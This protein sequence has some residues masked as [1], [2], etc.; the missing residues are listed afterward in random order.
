MPYE[1]LF[2][3]GDYKH[4]QVFANGLRLDLYIEYHF[5]YYSGATNYTL[6]KINK[7]NKQL[8]K[9]FARLHAKNVS[10]HFDIPLYHIDDNPDAQNGVVVS[11]RPGRN[12]YNI[13][14]LSAPAVILEPMFLSNPD[15][16]RILFQEGG[17]EDLANIL[18]SSI[19]EVLPDSSRIGFSVGHK[20]QRANPMDRGAAAYSK[21]EFTEAD[22]SEK[23]LLIS[24]M[25]LKHDIPVCY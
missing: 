25:Q 13:S 10:E 21:S 22:L 4:R 23:V 12:N 19:R 5:N 20:Y 16:L 3:T 1:V 7:S 9:D 17:I 15:H 2:V 6:C 14:L 18:T 11:S 24:Y 8:A